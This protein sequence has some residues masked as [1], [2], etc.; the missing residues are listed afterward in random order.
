[1]IRGVDN[2]MELAEVSDLLVAEPAV[3]TKIRIGYPRVSTS[4]QKLQRQID[5]LTAAGCRRI[6]ADTKSGKTAL[7]P[8]LRDGPND[9]AKAAGHQVA[10]VS[11]RPEPRH[12]ALS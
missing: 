3:R 10:R 1:M 2:A 8:P 12:C 11:H 5:A 7:R 9:G 4:G 6:F